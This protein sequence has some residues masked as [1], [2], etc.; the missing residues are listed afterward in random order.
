[1]LLLLLLDRDRCNAIFTHLHLEFDLAFLGFS[2]FLGL[3]KLRLVVSLEF[4]ES[5]F[6]FYLLDQG[7]HQNRTVENDQG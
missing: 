5:A 1:M 2:C 7:D 6:F 4:A 3:F